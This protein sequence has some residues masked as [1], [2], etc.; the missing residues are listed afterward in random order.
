MFKKDFALYRC[1]NCAYQW[2][3]FSK[4]DPRSCCGNVSIKR[5]H[6]ND[7]VSRDVAKNIAK[8]IRHSFDD[9]FYGEVK[10]DYVVL[11][12]AWSYKRHVIYL[13]TAELALQM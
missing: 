13:D 4:N 6:L 5:V 10:Q 11:H 7:A 12:A 8:V 2:L 9:T 1:N 3:V